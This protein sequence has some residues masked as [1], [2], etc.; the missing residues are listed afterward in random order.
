MIVGKNV[1][2]YY[3]R[4]ISNIQAVQRQNASAEQM[5]E[6]KALPLKWSTEEPV[7][8]GQWPMT[9]EELEALENL[10][11][12][13]LNAGHIEESISPCNSPVFVIKIKFGKCRMLADLRAMNIDI[14]PMGT[15]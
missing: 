11:Q 10:V 6:P 15:L 4:Q 8:V 13:Q 2:M 3:T 7:W 1:I 9:S 12:E 14:Q 5:E